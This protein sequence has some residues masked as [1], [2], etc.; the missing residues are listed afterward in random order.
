MHTKA[1]YEKLKDPIPPQALPVSP[2][3]G[4][5]TEIW[6]LSLYFAQLKKQFQCLGFGYFNKGS[7][8]QYS[9]VKKTLRILIVYK[10]S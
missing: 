2:N 1:A 10:C 6:C 4:Y 8:S 7:I 5:T 3:L 9:K